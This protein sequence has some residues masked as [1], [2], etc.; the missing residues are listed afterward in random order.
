MVA[1]C[2]ATCFHNPEVRVSKEV[3]AFALKSEESLKFSQKYTTE[4]SYEPA[5]ASPPYHSPSIPSPK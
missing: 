4:T 1:L 2:Q 3:S 5:E